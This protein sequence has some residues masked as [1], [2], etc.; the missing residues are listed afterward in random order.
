MEAGAVP[1]P[2]AIPGRLLAWAYVSGGRD[3]ALVV[4]W[5]FVFDCAQIAAPISGGPNRLAGVAA[6][7]GLA[8]LIVLGISGVIA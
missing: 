3:L 7:T 4:A 5:H 8:A 6:L 2:T 1:A